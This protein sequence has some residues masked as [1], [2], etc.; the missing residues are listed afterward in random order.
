M[1]KK[2]LFP[3]LLILALIA[4]LA[5]GAWVIVVVDPFNRFFPS[6]HQHGAP[7]GGDGHDHSGHDHGSHEGHNH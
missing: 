4:V 2:A 6:Q 7:T 1:L 5:A 3:L